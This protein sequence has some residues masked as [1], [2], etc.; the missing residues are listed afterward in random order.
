MAMSAFIYSRC[1]LLRFFTCFA[2]AVPKQLAFSW[3]K[4]IAAAKGIQIFN[5]L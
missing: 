2:A 4:P 3:S 5:V 1:Q